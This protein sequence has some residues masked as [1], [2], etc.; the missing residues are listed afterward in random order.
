[1]AYRIVV[2]LPKFSKIMWCT[3]LDF[4][5]CTELYVSSIKC[6]KTLLEIFIRNKKIRQEQESIPVGCVLPALHRTGGSVRG[7][8]P[9]DRDPLDRDPRK[10]QGTRDRD[11]H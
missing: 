5:Y 1:M 6:A 8:R 7:G 3:G 9:L 4:K 2:V 11:P 10:E